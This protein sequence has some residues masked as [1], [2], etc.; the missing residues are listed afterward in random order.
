MAALTSSQLFTAAKD[1]LSNF[2]TVAQLV[3]AGD[4]R[5]LMQISAQSVMLSMLSEQVEVARI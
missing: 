1:D 2:P 3:K 4:P 5:I